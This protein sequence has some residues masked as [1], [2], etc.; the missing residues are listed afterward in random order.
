[1]QIMMNGY[2]VI[3]LASYARFFRFV[4]QFPLCMPAPWY[5]LI[6]TLYE[7]LRFHQLFDAI[8]LAFQAKPR[9]GLWCP[10]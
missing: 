5:S 6:R 1:M 8:Y 10:R 7:P 2:F 4:T 3:H 9:L